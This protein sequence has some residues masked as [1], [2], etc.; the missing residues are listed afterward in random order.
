MAVSRG[1]IG[2]ARKNFLLPLNLRS[3]RGQRRQRPPAGRLSL[4]PEAAGVFLGAARPIASANHFRR[5]R[6]R[7]AIV[8]RADLSLESVEL[9]WSWAAGG[10]RP[11][12]WRAQS[13]WPAG[14]PSSSSPASQNGANSAAV[15]GRRA[16]KFKYK[17][18]LQI[19]ADVSVSPSVGVSRQ[20]TDSFVRP[21][22]PKRDGATSCRRRLD[23]RRA[24]VLPCRRGGQIHFWSFRFL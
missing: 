9:D 12:R 19:V 22:G 23:I 14:A 15:A 8:S 5:A 4:P 1:S 21:A 10:S 2:V 24:K 6:S 20:A 16:R 7:L 18:A 17:L 13:S 3:G 11:M